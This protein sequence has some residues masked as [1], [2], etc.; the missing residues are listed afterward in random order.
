M[1]CSSS[2]SAVSSWILQFYEDISVYEEDSHRKGN[3]IGSSFHM[4]K[5]WTRIRWLT[6]KSEAVEACGVTESDFNAD[7]EVVT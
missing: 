7:S 5:I 1:T 6:T 3:Q 4:N 2:S